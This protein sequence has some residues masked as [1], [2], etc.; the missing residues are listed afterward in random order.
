M[1]TNINVVLQKSHR[2]DGALDV[3]CWR[4][5]DRVDSVSH[6][7]TTFIIIRQKPGSCWP[8]IYRGLMIRKTRVQY[9]VTDSFFFEKK[10]VAV[11]PQSAQTYPQLVSSMEPSTC[12]DAIPKSATRMLFFSSSNKFSGFKSRWLKHE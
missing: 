2:V 5:F 11:S 12:S 8:K 1:F 4:M 6:Q 7:R 10:C 9:F 3:Q